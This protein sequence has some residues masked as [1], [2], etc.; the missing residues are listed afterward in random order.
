MMTND[1]LIISINEYFIKHPEAPYYQCRKDLNIGCKKFNEVKEN[2]EIF[3]KRKEEEKEREE[4]LEKAIN[5]YQNNDITLIECAKMHNITKNLLSSR[6]KKRNIKIV[7]HNYIPPRKD[8]TDAIEYWQQHEDCSYAKCASIFNISKNTL[9]KGL[10]ELNLYVPEINRYKSEDDLKKIALAIDY[11]K[12]NKTVSIKECSKKFG[13]PAHKINFE[14]KK[15]NIPIHGLIEANLNGTKYHLHSNNSYIYKN[16][17]TT[18]DEDF[19]ETINTE[20]KAYWLGFIL[21]DGC[22]TNN[23]ELSI[24]LAIRDYDHLH[25]FKKSLKSNAQIYESKTYLKRMQTY[26]A[27]CSISLYSKKISSD[28]K[29]HNIFPRKSTLEQPDLTIPKCLIHHYIRG[30]FDGDGWFSTYKRVT[31]YNKWECGFG[32][33]ERMLKYVQENCKKLGNINFPDPKPFSSFY[34]IEI[35][36]QVEILK[37]IDFIYSDATI[38][39]PRKYER[40]SLLCRLH[41]KTIGE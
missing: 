15:A 38:Y 19:F 27:T 2:L 10:K 4:N 6:L 1:T 33:S 30:F 5:Y 28:L 13:I 41:S 17:K 18:F 34:S 32:S 20:E 36:N 29:K 12:N 7:K 3:R 23:N 21:A 22:I 39:L 11:Y 8:I 40:A 26:Y 16:S 14:L 37:F 24:G 31:Y 9:I 35:T 25:R